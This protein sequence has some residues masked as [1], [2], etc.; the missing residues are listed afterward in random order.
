MRSAAA[1]LVAILAAFVLSGCGLTMAPE[2]GP[3]VALLNATCGKT[4]LG[5]TDCTGTVRNISDHELSGVGVKIR[6]LDYA[7]VAR[8]TASG[9][10]DKDPIRPGEESTWSLHTSVPVLTTTWN[11]DI[12]MNG[13]VILWDDR[14]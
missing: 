5:S 8:A 2:A 9:M 14:R 11:I 3:Q 12:T 10:I 6:F 7:K 4:V 1:L 13:G